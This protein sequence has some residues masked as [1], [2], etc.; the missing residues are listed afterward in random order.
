[1][2]LDKFAFGYRSMKEYIAILFGMSCTAY[3]VRVYVF[4]MREY[5][6]QLIFSCVFVPE[7]LILDCYLFVFLGYCQWLLLLPAC[8]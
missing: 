2:Y 7:G 1:M 6:I 3:V 4:F 5:G 8:I